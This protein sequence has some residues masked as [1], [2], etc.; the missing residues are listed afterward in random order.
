MLKQKLSLSGRLLYSINYEVITWREEEKKKTGRWNEAV[1]LILKKP[2]LIIFDLKLSALVIY[3][4][5]L[6]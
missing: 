1:V 2:R 4:T 6:Q 3:L 5:S